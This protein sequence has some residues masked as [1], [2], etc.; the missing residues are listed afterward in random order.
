MPRVSIIMPMFNAIGTVDRA[1]DSVVAQTERDWELIV[2]DDASADGSFEHVATRYSGEQRIR[3]LAQA[4][5][6]GPSAARNRAIGEAQGEW[7]AIL[8]A[9]DAWRPERLA[10]LCARAGDLDFVADNIAA[11]DDQ[12]GTETGTLFKPFRSSV[13]DLRS[14]LGG[15]LAGEFVN[16][17]L[18]KPM[19]RRAF[20]LDN[21]LGYD[22]NLRF[23]EDYVLY[24]EALCRRARFGL[25]NTADYI[26]TT[27]IGLRSKTV[28][29]HSKTRAD[30]HPVAHKLEAL[31]ASHRARL[32]DA[33]QQAFAQKIAE[34]LSID[35]WYRFR[36]LLN[37]RAPLQAFAVFGRSPYVRYRLIEI[38][39]R[40]L[41]LAP[42][43]WGPSS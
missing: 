43:V 16:A 33:E 11:Y 18:L 22:E 14:L 4:V 30:S 27:W 6:S 28:S 40:R 32:T 37:R 19:M 21:N 12:A 7:I 38:V 36:S 34:L 39:K 42:G 20:L 13:L 35:D 15:R 23:S 2:V 25:T 41:G 5:N 10:R 29:Q 24:C 3:C 1:I 8:D 26:Y 31:L 9:D 17:G